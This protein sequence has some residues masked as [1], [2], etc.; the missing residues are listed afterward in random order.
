MFNNFLNIHLVIFNHSFP[1]KKHF[2]KQKNKTWLTTGIKIS[3]AHKREL[4]VLSRTTGNPELV[5]HCKEYCKILSDTIKLPKK[6]HY[7]NLS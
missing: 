6:L 3:C 7:N 1:Y 2:T 5:K 4:Y